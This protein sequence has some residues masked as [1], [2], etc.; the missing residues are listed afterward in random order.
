M[1]RQ[2]EAN[3]QDG[4]QMDCSCAKKQ[5][6][7]GQMMTDLDMGYKIGLHKQVCFWDLKISVEFS[8]LLPSTMSTRPSLSIAT[9]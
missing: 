2:V 6:Q 8:P 7:S 9:V 5:K 1:G 3:H 4:L